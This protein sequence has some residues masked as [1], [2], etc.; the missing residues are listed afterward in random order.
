[1]IRSRLPRPLF[2]PAETG[3]AAGALPEW[4]LS[5]LYASPDDPAIERDLEAAAAAARDL[6]DRARWRFW[7]L[8]GVS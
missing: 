3:A 7:V 8:T 2:H 4:D 6:A 1:M 5:A